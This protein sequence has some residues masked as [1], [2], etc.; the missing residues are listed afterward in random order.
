MKVEMIGN[1]ILIKQSEGQKEVAGIEIAEPHVKKLKE[2]IVVA[3]NDSFIHG[4]TG[5]SE[6]IKCSV[7]DKVKYQPFGG[8]EVEIENEKFVVL[9][10]EDLYYIYN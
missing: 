4:H 5:V 1:K 2:G 6:K 8:Q 10:Y 9:K 7:G 3:C